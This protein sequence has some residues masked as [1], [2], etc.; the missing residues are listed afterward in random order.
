MHLGVAVATGASGNGDK[1]GGIRGPDGSG[2][3][4]VIVYPPEPPPSGKRVEVPLHGLRIGGEGNDFVLPDWDGTVA[5]ITRLPGVPSDE[6]GW[7]IIQVAGKIEVNGEAVDG[8]RELTTRDRVEIAGMGFVFLGGSTSEN[9]YHELI[10]RLTITDFE[11]QCHNAR[12]FTEALEREEIRATRHQL[13]LSIAVLDFSSSIERTSLGQLMRKAA[14]RLGSAVHGDWV[15][16][17]LTEHELGVVAPEATEGTLLAKVERQ[18]HQSRWPPDSPQFTR[19]RIG[20]ATLSSEVSGA[21]LV[22][23]AR[24]SI[25]SA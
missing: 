24:A 11:T 7:R 22:E 4:L 16:A 9:E 10:Y 1:P 3:W 15:L 23:K 14:D 21:Q 25:Q 12:Y 18:F 6:D 2:A 8:S 20:I 17:R 19:P 13:P 5:E